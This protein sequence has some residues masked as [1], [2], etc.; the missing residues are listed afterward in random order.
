MSTQLY[1]PSWHRVANLTPSLR[2]HAQIH[3]HHYRGLL[4]YV[5]QDHLSSRVHRF[6]PSAYYVLGL[7]DGS[8]T[9]QEIWDS[10]INELGDEA[11]TQDEIIRLLGQLHSGCIA[12]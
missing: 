10:C 11:P 12:M 7:M 9:V 4:W 2:A 3:R 1:S 8:R 5:L 6:T